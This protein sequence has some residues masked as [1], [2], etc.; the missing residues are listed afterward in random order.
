MAVAQATATLFKNF[1]STASTYYVTHAIGSSKRQASGGSYRVPRRR[2]NPSVH[3]SSGTYRTRDAWSAPLHCRYL[4]A[5]TRAAAVTRGTPARSDGIE[6][7]TRYR[8]E[9][10]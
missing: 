5:D 1:H 10:N 9:S 7:D 2:G 3:R 8:Q 4:Q 6:R